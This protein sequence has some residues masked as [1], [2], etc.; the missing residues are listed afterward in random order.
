ME[1]NLRTV[2]TAWFSGIFVDNTDTSAL[3]RWKKLYIIYNSTE[4]RLSLPLKEGEW[5][6]LADGADSFIWK[7]NRK[8]EKAEVSPVSVLILGQR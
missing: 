3:S 8:T 5:E 7:E 6:I 1:K 2:E 4:K